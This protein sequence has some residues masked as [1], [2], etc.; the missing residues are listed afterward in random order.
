MTNSTVLRTSRLQP[1]EL[2]LQ[3]VA[4]DRVDGAERLV[5]QQHQRV[6]GQRAGHADP[7]PLA[8]GELVRVALGVAC[9][10]EPDQLEQLVD[11]GRV[12]L[13]CPSRAAAG[14]VATLSRRSGAG[15]A[16]RAG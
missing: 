2:L 15:T 11:P 10:V 8:A 9:R 3:P 1:Q 6:G 14:T 12:A 13:A 5:H 4:H 7:L 16:R